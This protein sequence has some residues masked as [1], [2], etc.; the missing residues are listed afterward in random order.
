M[1]LRIADDGRTS[2]DRMQ[3]SPF[4]SLQSLPRTERVREIRRRVADDVYR[5]IEVIDEIA[6]R[7][8]RSGD[9]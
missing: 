9:L 3:M 8:I 2:P 6:R 4:Q 1:H 5:S 7:I